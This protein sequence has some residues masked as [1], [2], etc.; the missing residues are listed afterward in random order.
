MLRGRFLASA[1]LVALVSVAS[2]VVGTSAESPASAAGSGWTLMS[3]P[4]QTAG[5]TVNWD[6]LSCTSA[7]FCIAV[8]TAPPQLTPP[9][10]AQVQMWDGSSW[11]DQDLPVIAGATVDQPTAVSCL[12]SSFCMVVGY[13]NSGAYAAAW[14]GSAWTAL[15]VQAPPDGPYALL[16]SVTCLNPTDCEAVGQDVSANTTLAEQWDG[17]TWTIVPSQNTT[18]I[19]SSLD[20]L[21]CLDAT[22]C[23]AVGQANDQP[24]AEQ[25]DGSAWSI[26]ATPG[27]SGTSQLGSISCASLSFCEA[28]GA[29]W[30]PG[31]QGGTTPLIETWDGSSWS[32]A[33]SPIAPVAG[34]NA[35]VLNVDCY[36]QISCVAVGNGP[37]S[38]L[39]L[40]YASGTWLSVSGPPPP[41]GLTGE[42][43][44]AV[45]CVSSWACVVG[46]TAASSGNVQ[47]FFSEGAVSSPGAP[48]ATITS[49][50][51]GATYTPGQVVATAFTCIEGFAG[52]G[53]SSCNDSNG[54]TSPGTLDTSTVGAHTYSVTAMS[55]DGQSG[56]SSITYLVAEAPTAT[57]TSPPSGQLYAVNQVVPTT[58]TCTD[59]AGGPGISICED[60]TNLT[61]PSVLPTG[62]PGTYGYSVGARSNDGLYGT[63]SITYT[64][65]APP[66][67]S[68]ISLPLT[69]NTVGLNQIVHTSFSCVEGDYGPGLSSCLD[70]NGSASPGML[71]TSTLGS[72]T[73]SVTATSS[74]GQSHTASVPY[75]VAD[76]PTITITTPAAGATYGQGETVTTDFSCSDGTDGTGIYLCDD[77]NSSPSPGT[78]DTSTIGL[79]TY[80]VE[81][82]SYDGLS[83]TASV[84]YLVVNPTTRTNLSASANPAFA[85]RAVTY[86]AQV[87]PNPGGGT[88]AFTDGGT[89]IPGCGAVPVNSATGEA[90]CSVTYTSK[91]THSIVAAFSGAAFWQSS[92]SGLLAEKVK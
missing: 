8:G 72:H 84:S 66:S 30:L 16:T 92:T 87:N 48:S 20:A 65:A 11:S 22:H 68:S 83:T 36:N 53:L 73:Y 28:V 86:T 21:S 57:I 51:S 9:L 37:S 85:R 80:T 62:N 19:R 50:A 59:G 31:T 34:A 63:T 44:L 71:D 12:S 2:V 29:N 89:T 61:S 67:V 17:S 27:P 14:D 24:L 13:T 79:H 90:K 23:W 70:S 18:G 75:I 32:I 33:P 3:G 40:D 38:P 7:T 82:Q 6:S 15:S 55:S 78:L 4:P 46:G 56:T 81:A 45:S 41:P 10:P 60:S 26:V 74:D 5:Q 88:I 54:S 91:G 69:T 64:V 49:P 77:S 25:F 1:V 76:P 42:S 35:M 58:F 43:V 39:V 47:T 52:P